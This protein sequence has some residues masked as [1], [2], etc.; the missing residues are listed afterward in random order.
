MLYWRNL[1][2]LCIFMGVL[3]EKLLEPEIQFFGL[4]SRNF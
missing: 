1:L 3:T 4:I 2:Q